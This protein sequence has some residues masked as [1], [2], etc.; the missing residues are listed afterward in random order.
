MLVAATAALAVGSLAELGDARAQG[1]DLDGVVNLNT[2][3]PEL[4]ELLPGIG[5]AK[6][7]DILSYRRR[8]P[9]RTVDE[10]VRIKGIGRKM[11]RRLRAHLA[12]SGPTTAHAVRRVLEP[13]PPPAPPPLRKPP[14]VPPPPLPRPRIK[15]QRTPE[16][17]PALANH[18][19]RPP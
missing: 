4:L 15:N 3:Q 2:A 17:P 6:V 14:S 9:F 16:G 12:V 1:K 19:A 5:P 13:E 18:C 8:R 11:V 10:L 7:R